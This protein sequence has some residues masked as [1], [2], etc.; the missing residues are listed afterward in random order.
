MSGA[1]SHVG[2]ALRFPQATHDITMHLDLRVQG[3]AKPDLA[4]RVGVGLAGS[5]VEER[6]GRERQ[7]PRYLFLRNFLL[8]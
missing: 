6:G 4:E 3:P 7:Q 8:L 2:R 5:R 1:L